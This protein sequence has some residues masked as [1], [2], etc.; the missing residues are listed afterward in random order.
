MIIVRILGGVGSQLISFSF[1]YVV[2]KIC[3]DEICL[4]V[5]DYYNG[6]VWQYALDYLNLPDYNKVKLF[7]KKEREEILNSC[8][9]IIEKSETIRS[10]NELEKL[11]TDKH[12]TGNIYI[13]GY[14]NTDVCTKEEL[15]ELKY[16]F[17]IKENK[18]YLDEIRKQIS[19]EVSVSV[20][21]RRGDATTDDDNYYFAAIEYIKELYPE[22]VFYFFSVE[23]SVEMIKKLFGYDEN[24][25][26][27]RFSGNYQE[28]IDEISCIAACKI[29][30]VSSGSSYSLFGAWIDNKKDKLTILSYKPFSI[31][32]DI[33][34]S[35]HIILEEAQIYSLSMKYKST[36]KKN[37]FNYNN[38][39]IIK[40]LEDI[41]YNISNNCLKAREIISY[42]FSH[43]ELYTENI[44]MQLLYFMG[45]IYYNEQKFVAAGQ[46]FEKCVMYKHVNN[47][48]LNY[49][50]ECYKRQEIGLYKINLINCIHKYNKLSKYHFIIISDI[51]LYSR[52]NNLMISIGMWLS[53][54]GH[55]VSLINPPKKVLL[56]KIEGDSEEA[57]KYMQK[58]KEVL[59]GAFYLDLDTYP[60]VIN[61]N[62]NTCYSALINSLSGEKVIINKF[63]R[64][65]REDVKLQNSMVIHADFGVNRKEDKENILFAAENSDFIMTINNNFDDKKYKDKLI[66]LENKNFKNIQFGHQKL[67]YSYFYYNTPLLYEILDK[68]HELIN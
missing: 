1:A 51:D 37:N 9:L 33:K 58:N 7:T 39:L 13:D 30:I 54:I 44:W 32:L 61:C 17:S 53:I 67:F 11:I 24:Y 3:S 2:S 43:A 29:H 15:H 65:F 31:F 55:K 21:I 10:R 36:H 52:C 18:N 26:Y 14:G 20:H 62:N 22:A 25:H 6:Y 48:I 46:I 35:D 59:P 64:L 16:I 19:N 57:V 49:L 23:T 40:Q 42:L 28:T 45:E 27:I 12:L 8:D 38:S 34:E 5:S 56:K 66:Q 68:I 4:D 63:G 50:T 47:K 41:E 60:S